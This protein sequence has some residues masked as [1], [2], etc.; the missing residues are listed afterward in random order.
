MVGAILGHRYEECSRWLRSKPIR[1]WWFSCYCA[2]EFTGAFVRGARHS[3]G[4][5]THKD[6][7]GRG[8]RTLKVASD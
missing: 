8:R 1:P 4:R 3:L 2:K 7:K 5:R 6:E